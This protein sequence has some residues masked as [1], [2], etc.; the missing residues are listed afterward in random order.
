M[1]LSVKWGR[2]RGLQSNTLSTHHEFSQTCLVC[3]SHL[4]QPSRLISSQPRIRS[5]YQPQSQPHLRR[6]RRSHAPQSG[7]VPLDIAARKLS[8]THSLGN[9]GDRSSGDDA[10]DDSAGARAA[11]GIFFRDER[12]LISKRQAPG[13]DSGGDEGDGGGDITSSVHESRR[14]GGCSDGEGVLPRSLAEELRELERLYGAG[15]YRLW[16]QE[17]SLTGRTA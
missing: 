2:E 14:G 6:N 4:H 1:S 3:L 9:R 7:A 8:L 5:Q 17:R 11:A 12:L 10:L 16:S 13:G 15:A